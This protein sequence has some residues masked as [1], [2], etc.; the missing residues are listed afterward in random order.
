MSTHFH[1][2]RFVKLA[3]LASSAAVLPGCLPKAPPS[4][5]DPAVLKEARERPVLQ[6]SL[7]PDPILLENIELLRRDDQFFVQV[8][9]RDGGTG[10]ALTNRRLMNSVYPLFLNRVA[11]FFEGKDARDLETL[12]DGVFVHDLNYKWQGLALWVCVAWLELAVLDLMGKH[13]DRSAGE[14]FGPRLR[15]RSPIYYANGNRTDPPEVVVEQLA[16]LIERS[17]ARAIKFKLGARMRFDDASNARDRALIPM[18]RERFGPEATLFV[19]ANSSFDV[20]TAIQ[21]GRFL[22]EY[23]YDF[24]EE[25]VRFDDFEG[26]KKV[27]DALRVPIAGGEQETSM[28]RFQ[29][30]IE[31]RGVQ[32]AQP[33]LLFFGGMIRSIRL[34]RMAEAVDM[35]VVP[36]MSGHGLGILYVLHYAS[37]VPNASA[38]QEYKGEG[39]RLPYEVVGTGRPLA[40]VDGEIAIPDGPGLGVAFSPDYMRDARPVIL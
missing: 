33:D 30:L 2:R 28:R 17:G 32:I 36:H 11:P 5:A 16:G 22:E 37:V 39:D 27:A 29:W 21:M 8:R 18:V 34:A 24:F 3:G 31:Q 14:L 35:Q 6:R 20:P 15:E 10:L 12:I 1:R 7:F 26:T 19:D 38:F 40:A 4:T 13:V 25:P 23:K 9:S